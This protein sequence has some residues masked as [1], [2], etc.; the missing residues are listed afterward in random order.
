MFLKSRILAF[1]AVAALA[2]AGSFAVADGG[3]CGAS[4]A[5]KS[6]ASACTA[7]GDKSASAVPGGAEK[8]GSATAAKSETCTA[9]EKAACTADKTAC[10]GKGDKS[11]SAVPGGAE[12]GANATAA[13]TESCTAGE[14]TVCTTGDKSASAVP[15]GA[16]KDG[17]ATG[18]KA[19]GDGSTAAKKAD[20]HSGHDHSASKD[21]GSK[22]K[23]DKADKKA[24]KKGKKKEDSGAELALGAKVPDL[25]GVE[26][27]TGKAV[28][29]SEAAAGAK[30]TVVVFINQTCPYVV[31]AVPRVSAIAKE[32]ADKGVKVIAVD[33][34]VNNSEED[35]KKYAAELPFPV[36]ID[37]SSKSAVD[38]HATYTPQVF[39]TDGSGN[40]KYRGALDGAVAQRAEKSDGKN[41]AIDA[42]DA[43]L[44]GKEPA[45]ATTKGVGCSI[46]FAK[47]AK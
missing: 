21:D 13:K 19:S 22:A 20:D 17:A 41:Y 23:A 14:K 24:E 6:S 25:S 31:P 29:L 4:S 9:A 38:F 37:R 46:K 11:T 12:K 8:D 33:A 1:A 40:L 34:G 39:I 43:V 27:K 10:T 36:L 2:G 3:S 35:I 5:G 47:G 28:K 42:L 30:A 44:E 7:K 26:T 45:V 32:Y 15:G 16:E 18:V